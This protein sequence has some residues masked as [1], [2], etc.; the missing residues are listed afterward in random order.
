MNFFMHIGQFFQISDFWWFSYIFSWIKPLVDAIIMKCM[1]AG[2]HATKIAI[3]Q[4]ILAD[5]A[6]IWGISLRNLH[7][8][9]HGDIFEINEVWFDPWESLLLDFRFYRWKVDISSSCAIIIGH[10]RWLRI[11]NVNEMLILGLVFDLSE[12]SLI[13]IRNSLI[14]VLH[15]NDISFLLIATSHNHSDEKDDC[16]YYE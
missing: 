14:D 6:T 5:G 4:F 7:L 11:I 15:S 2:K 8:G 10:L 12:L 3:I 16:D 13:N 1:Q 9:N